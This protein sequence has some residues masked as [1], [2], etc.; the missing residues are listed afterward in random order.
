MNLFCF[1][2][3]Y[4]IVC[5]CL[6]VCL[7]V[8]F[9]V[10]LYLSVSLSYPCTLLIDLLLFHRHCS[11]SFIPLPPFPLIS[12][13]LRLLL[14]PPSTYLQLNPVKQVEKFT[15]SDCLLEMRIYWH[16]ST[17]IYLVCVWWRAWFIF[18]SPTCLICTCPP[19]WVVN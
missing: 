3:Y 6:S 19:V 17:F 8:C 18:L 4:S 14:F 1:V 16:L 2:L 10:W 7:S 15:L 11:S 12:P 13:S 5:I 9:S